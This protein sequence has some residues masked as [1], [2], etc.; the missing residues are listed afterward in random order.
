LRVPNPRFEM[1]KS[2][3]KRKTKSRCKCHQKDKPR[4]VILFCDALLGGFVGMCIA[5]LLVYVALPYFGWTLDL[6]IVTKEN[7]TGLWVSI[8]GVALNVMWALYYGC[9]KS[10]AGVGLSVVTALTV[11]NSYGL[12]NF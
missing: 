11:A 12:F 6:S 10:L 5:L 8:V 1:A 3:S 4:G 9:Q 7:L 2:K